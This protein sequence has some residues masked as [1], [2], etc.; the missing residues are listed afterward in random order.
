V[1]GGWPAAR[2]A[3]SKG[4]DIADND[5]LARLRELLE[6]DFSGCAGEVVETEGDG[7]RGVDGDIVGI[8]DGGGA[9][10]V[11]DDEGYGIG[12]WNRENGDRVLKV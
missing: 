2:G 12:A 1:L 4:P 5:P 10:G 11:L 6:L 7:R 3:V 9:A 8:A